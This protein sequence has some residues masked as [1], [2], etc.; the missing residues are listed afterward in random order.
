MFLWFTNV[1]SFVL[2]SSSCGNVQSQTF[3]LQNCDLSEMLEEYFC[4]SGSKHI[5]MDPS[6]KMPKFVSISKI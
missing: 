6:E 5:S 2:M 4:N 3:N 1:S